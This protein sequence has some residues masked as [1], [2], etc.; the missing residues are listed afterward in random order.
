MVP[1]QVIKLIQAEIGED[2]GKRDA[3]KKQYFLQGQTK[4]IDAQ[5]ITW[6]KVPDADLGKNRIPNQKRNRY[7]KRAQKK[8]FEGLVEIDFWMEG[9]D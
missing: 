4:K 9:K 3:E 5:Q 8:C 6:I 1:P 7:D 2:T